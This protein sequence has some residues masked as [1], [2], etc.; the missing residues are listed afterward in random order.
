M[1]IEKWKINIILNRLFYEISDLSSTYVKMYRYRYRALV[2]A[3]GF[4]RPVPQ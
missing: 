3:R 1:T 2:A 4:A